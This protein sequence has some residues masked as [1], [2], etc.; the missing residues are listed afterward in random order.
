VGESEEQQRTGRKEGNVHGNWQ[1]QAMG[2]HLGGGA[3]SIAL[4]GQRES[5]RL[6]QRLAKN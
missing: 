2:L 5:K 6:K 4:A 3:A 1:S